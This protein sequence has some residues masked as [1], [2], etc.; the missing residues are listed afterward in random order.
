M[1]DI[2]YVY[3]DGCAGTGCTFTMYINQVAFSLDEPIS[4]VI[5]TPAEILGNPCENNQIAATCLGDELIVKVT[6]DDS[7]PSEPPSPFGDACE[8]Y[9]P[10]LDADFFWTIIPALSL[11]HI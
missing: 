4:V 7:S 1:G 6:H 9:D 10:T 8:T 2:Y 11:I 3:V 5:D